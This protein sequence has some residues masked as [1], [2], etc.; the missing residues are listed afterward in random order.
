MG[1]ITVITMGLVIF[2]RT[3]FGF[4]SR[5]HSY[6]SKFQN[7]KRILPLIAIQNSDDVEVVVA[8]YLKRKKSCLCSRAGAR[9]K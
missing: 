6:L 3:M 9:G 7:H 8:S 1:F 4:R 2:R 5:Y